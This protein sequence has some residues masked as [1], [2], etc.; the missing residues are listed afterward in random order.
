MGGGIKMTGQKSMGQM[1]RFGGQQP[2]NPK[3]SNVVDPLDAPQLPP[4]SASQKVENL[5]PPSV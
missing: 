1:Q 4:T 2:S 5:S 3:G